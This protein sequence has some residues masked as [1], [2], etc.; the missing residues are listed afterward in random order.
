MEFHWWYILIVLVVV[1]IIFG[2]S[3]G[4]VVVKRY[5]ANMQILDERFSDCRPEADYTI[6][7]EGKPEKIDIDIENL[8]IPVGDELELHLNGNLLAKIEVKRNHEAE[9]EHWSDEAVTFPKIKAGDELVVKYQNTD[10]LKGS[11]S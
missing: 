4:G 7:K 5:T 10:V 6:F 11:F 2:K 8:S 3:K 9:F 1:F